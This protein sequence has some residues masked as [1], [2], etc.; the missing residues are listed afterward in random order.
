MI[1]LVLALS[2]TFLCLFTVWQVAMSK[3]DRQK[4]PNVLRWMD[5]VQVL[6]R[7]NPPVYRLLLLVGAYMCDFY[8]S[9]FV[10]CYLQ[11]S[12]MVK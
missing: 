6:L 3:S 8:I 9:H 4:I 5:Y 10:Y 11:C 12:F 1:L 2:H 7:Y